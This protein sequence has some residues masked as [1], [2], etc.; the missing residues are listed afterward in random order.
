MFKYNYFN[1]KKSSIGHRTLSF[2]DKEILISDSES[3]QNLGLETAIANTL[4]YI[5]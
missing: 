2:K 1:G 5:P 4:G 3:A